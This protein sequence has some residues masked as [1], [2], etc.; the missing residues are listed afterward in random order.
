MVLP[1]IRQIMVILFI[2]LSG[3]SAQTITLTA[4]VSP[5]I[6]REGDDYF[7]DVL[8]DPCDFDTRRDFGWEE[9][10]SETSITATNGQW[11]GVF[12]DSGGGYVFPL[13]QGFELALNTGKTGARFPLLSSKY[14][15]ISF[16]IKA[17]I[18]KETVINWT[19]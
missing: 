11:R 4:P 1:S 17:S 16:M 8:N 6:I 12:D 2:S 19:R 13:F 15:G 14:T 7:S 5:V 10:F 9:H 18:A 3:L